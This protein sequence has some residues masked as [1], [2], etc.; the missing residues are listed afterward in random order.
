MNT[1]ALFCKEKH[2]REYKTCFGQN[3][4]SGQKASPCAVEMSPITVGTTKNGVERHEGAGKRLSWLFCLMGAAVRIK[5]RGS[6]S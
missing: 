3:S 1:L 4:L 2:L 6:F 5:A